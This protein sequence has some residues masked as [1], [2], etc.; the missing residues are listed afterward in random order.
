MLIGVLS[1]WNI[2][3]SLLSTT[4]LHFTIDAKTWILLHENIQ[5]LL[6]GEA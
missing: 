6:F 3:A 1:F 2:T 4:T 5:K